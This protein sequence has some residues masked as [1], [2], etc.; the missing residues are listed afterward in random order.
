MSA[1][2][3]LEHYHERERFGITPSD[4]VVPVVIPTRVRRKSTEFKRAVAEKRLAFFS[5][6]YGSNAPATWLI[7]GQ[8]IDWTFDTLGA[9]SKC[10]DLSKSRAVFIL[11]TPTTYAA[12]SASRGLA[13]NYDRVADDSQRFISYLSCH[14]EDLDVERV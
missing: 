10:V 1:V 5:S 3:T 11:P 12:R 7:H 9:L 14:F 2:G 8:A 6:I 13:M 4:I